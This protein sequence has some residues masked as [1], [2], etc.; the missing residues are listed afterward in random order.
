LYPSLALY[1]LQ[2]ILRTRFVPDPNE[3]EGDAIEFD[4]FKKNCCVLPNERQNR[5][6][7]SKGKLV[8]GLATKVDP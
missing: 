1:P 5:T 3:K 2:P 8:F 4:P 7:E 6:L